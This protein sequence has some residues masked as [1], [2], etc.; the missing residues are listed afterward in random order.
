MATRS[1]P[2]A[3]WRVESIGGKTQLVRLIAPLAVQRGHEKTICICIG[4]KRLRELVPI[5][6]DLGVKV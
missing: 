6:N 3:L 5:L 4:S 1:R 2:N